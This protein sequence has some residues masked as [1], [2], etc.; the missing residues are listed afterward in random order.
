MILIAFIQFVPKYV[1]MS[2]TRESPVEAGISVVVGTTIGVAN[3]QYIHGQF[4]KS[5]IYTPAN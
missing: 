3:H 5:T 1:C 4:A 2:H